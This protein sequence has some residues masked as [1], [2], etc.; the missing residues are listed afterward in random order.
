M[1]TRDFVDPDLIRV[2]NSEGYL[3]VIRG[4]KIR[5]VI[6]GEIH[7][8]QE[9]LAKQAELIEILRPQIVLH[10]MGHG[11]IYEQRTGGYSW[12]SRRKISRD[13]RFFFNSMGRGFPSLLIQQADKL[14]RKIIGIDFTML[15]LDLAWRNLAILYPRRFKWFQYGKHSF[16]GIPFKKKRSKL[17]VYNPGSHNY[18]ITG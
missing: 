4:S 7:G 17:Y 18:K 15:E 3:I 5:S 8:N 14:G 12:N 2:W 10:E 13:D 11:L 9:H 1:K 6:L 16:E